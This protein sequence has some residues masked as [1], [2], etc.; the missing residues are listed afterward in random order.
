[1]LSADSS[2]PRWRKSSFS[3]A[4][5]CVEVAIQDQDKLVL[6]RDSKRENEN[7]GILSASPSAWRKFIQAVQVQ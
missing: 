6:V 3:D 2:A 7:N 4:G 1:M 5:H